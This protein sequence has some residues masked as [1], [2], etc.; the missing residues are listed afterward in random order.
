MVTTKRRLSREELAAMSPTDMRQ[1]LRKDGWEIDYTACQYWCHGYTQHAVAIL[2]ADYA[3][4]FLGFCLRNPR[5]FPVA[6]VCTPGSFHPEFLAP[7]ADIRTDCGKYNVYKNGELIDQPTNILE[8]WKDDMVAFFGG[9]IQPFAQIFRDR[10]VKYRT[11]GGYTSNISSVPSG[12][13][14]CEN[15]HVAGLLFETSLDAVRAIQITSELPFTHGYPIFIGKPE[16]IGVDL[17]KPEWNPYPDEPPPPP[18]PNEIFMAWP[19]SVS[20]IKLIQVARPP[21]AMTAQPG[22][23]FISDHRTLEFRSSFST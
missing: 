10:T 4:E 18:R 16:T 23:T 14:K 7:E 21:I 12:R 15:L 2:P 9:C 1:I 19:G 3:F 11:M 6:E 20:A 13:F 5:T 17:L 22:M 8:Y